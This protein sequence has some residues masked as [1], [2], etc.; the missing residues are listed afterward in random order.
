MIAEI[1]LSAAISISQI[2]ANIE[3]IATRTESDAAV[4]NALCIASDR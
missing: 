2:V 1:I 4:I 3:T